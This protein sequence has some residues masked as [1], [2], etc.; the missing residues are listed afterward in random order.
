MPEVSAGRDRRIG[1]DQLPATVAGPVRTAVGRSA[2]AAK[3]RVRGSERRNGG[4]GDPKGGAAAGHTPP[5]PSAG[6]ALGGRGPV[7]KSLAARS[8]PRLAP[9]PRPASR[10]WV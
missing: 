3:A 9:P 5:P 6:P 1:V 10:G 2:V 7:M 8:L 4:G